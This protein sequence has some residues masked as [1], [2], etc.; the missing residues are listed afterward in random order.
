MCE[1]F[2]VLYSD[3]ESEIKLYQEIILNTY[4]PEPTRTALQKPSWN[5]QRKIANI[6]F[7]DFEAVGAFYSQR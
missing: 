1:I 7:L 5:Y 4:V 6:G 2:V 3:G